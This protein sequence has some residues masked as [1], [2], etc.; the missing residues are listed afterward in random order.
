[1]RFFYIIL[2]LILFNSCGSFN[3]IPS[4]FTKEI[5]KGGDFY[6]TTF[7]DIKDTSKDYIVYIEGDG[8]I[9]LNNKTP[10]NDPT[11]KNKLVLNLAAEDKRYNIIYISRPCQYTPLELNDK[12]NNYEYWT[13]RRWSEETVLS[14]NEVIEKITR[15]GDVHLIGFSGGGGIAVLIAS[16]NKNIKSIVTIAGNLDHIKFNKIHKAR[17]CK[18]SL[19]P[20]DYTDKIFNIPQ[21]HIV[22]RKDTI[23]SESIIDDFIN[24]SK[25]DCY[26]VNQNYSI[27]QK[28]SI[29]NDVNLNYIQNKNCNIQKIVCFHCSHASD[30]WLVFWKKFLKTQYKVK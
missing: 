13:S 8:L 21:I 25:S 5:I 16:I 15:N 17:Q 12:C 1:M 29:K 26:N 14:M 24:K 23:I 20:I 11:P 9:T 10:H 18:L 7:H 30:S 22:G 3:K 19:N 4:R 28:T 2:I 27:L 6:I